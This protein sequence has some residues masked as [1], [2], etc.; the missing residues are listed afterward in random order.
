MQYRTS[1]EWC[2]SREHIAHNCSRAH[3]D[4]CKS[5]NFRG[6]FN[7]ADFAGLWQLAKVNRRP[8]SDVAVSVW[9]QWWPI[10]CKRQ[11]LKNQPFSQ[12][13]VTAKCV[14]PGSAKVSHLRKFVDLQYSF[15]ALAKFFDPNVRWECR[16]K[17]TLPASILAQKAPNRGPSL[18]DFQS[19]FSNL[20]VQSKISFPTFR[21]IFPLAV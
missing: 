2:S 7:F 20:S 1:F 21:P 16:F 3:A 4:Y 18:D 11:D 15:C 6:H 13:L 8:T 19:I 14:F 17:A 9:T 10:Q 12:S 5:R